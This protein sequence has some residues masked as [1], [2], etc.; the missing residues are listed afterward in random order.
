M[1]ISHWLSQNYGG[2]PYAAAWFGESDVAWIAEHRFDHIRLPVDFRVCVKADGSLDDEKLKPIWSVIGWAR[3]RGL[4]IVL[5]AHFL[6]G[7]DFNSKGGDN[8]VF[9]DAA[10]TE[11]VGAL[12]REI[13]ERF[14]KEGDWLRFEI[15]NEPVVAKNAE[16]NPFMHR[17][18]ARIRETNPTRFVYVTSNRWSAF[19][20][21]PDV[22]LPD[23]RKIALTIHNYEPLIFTHQRAQWVGYKP[24]MPAVPFPGVVPDLT[25]HFEPGIHP[26]NLR[27]GEN[28][29]V[30]KVQEA[31]VAVENWVKKTRPGLEMDVGEFGV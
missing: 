22:D 28:L 30:E 23:D 18:L 3:T 17:M 10:L 20:S 6:P 13:G 5:D 21:V 9:T 14:A 4:G 16:L 2:R 11:K 19:S 15:L 27:Q 29:T 8:R 1:N 25:G 31:F 12:W 24:T 7:A 26:N